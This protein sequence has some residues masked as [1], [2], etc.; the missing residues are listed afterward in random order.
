MFFYVSGQKSVQ[1]TGGKK[2]TLLVRDDFTKLK[3]LHFMRSKD[4]VTKYFS[5][6][7]ADYRFTGVPPPAEVVRSDNA[8]ECQGGVFAN[9]CRE[10]AIRQEL[11]TGN[12]P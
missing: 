8:A 2:Y 11:A 4:E 7:L 1:S 12:T 5:Q 9:L 3:A 6:Y 10:R